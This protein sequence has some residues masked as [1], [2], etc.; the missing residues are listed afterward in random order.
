[1]LENTNIT[2]IIGFPSGIYKHT[3]ITTAIVIFRNDKSGTKSIK[4][5]RVEANSNKECGT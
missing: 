2:D 3:G 5:S 1:M 4:F